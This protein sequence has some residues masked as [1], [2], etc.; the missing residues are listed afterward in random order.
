[1][2]KYNFLRDPSDPSEPTGGSAG[3]LSPQARRLLIIGIVGI[4]VAGGLYVYTTYFVEIP[5]PPPPPLALR[6][7]RVQPPAVPPPERPPV[8][9]REVVTA[10]PPP[11]PISPPGVKPKAVTP[12]VSLRKP[13]PQKKAEIAAPAVKGP[14]ARV[15]PEVAKPAKAPPERPKPAETLAKVE[16]PASKARTRKDYSIQVASLVR[17]RNALSLKERLEKLGYNPIIRTTTARITR[18]RVFAGEYSSREEAE[19][20]ARRMNVDG[21][22]SNLVEGESG[23]FRLE[24][25]SFF[26]LNKAIDLAHDLQKKTYTPKIVSEAASTPIHQVRVGE[27]ENRAE[28]LKVI[29]VLKGKGFAPL[30]VK[31]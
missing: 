11:M 9:R 17:K 18:H 14:K 10:P 23:K 31:R 7:R 26:Q 3:S 19:Q 6:K 8:V 24:V 1:V 25:G 12:P 28:A 4:V 22:P 2:K 13:E 20:T 15:A 30:I 16:R 27:Y 5:P 29:E 21:V